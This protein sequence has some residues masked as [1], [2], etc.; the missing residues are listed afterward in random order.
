MGDAEERYGAALELYR[1]TD[2]SVREIC[3][4]TNVSVG[5]FRSYLQRRHRDLMLVRYGVKVTP[6]KAST[7]KLRK[8]R[9][10]SPQTHAKYKDAILA[11][12]DAEYIECT[13]SEIA[14]IFHL[15][16]T[17]L[18]NQLRNHFP[19]ILERR[20]KE[21]QRLGINDNR[22][23]G[24]KAES[25]E[26]YA[27]AVEH[28]RNSD[29]TIPQTAEKYNLSYSGLREHVLRY[30]KEL[31]L[32]REDKRRQ[33]EGSKKRGEITGNGQRHL[34]SDEQ[35][36][37]YEKAI[38]LYRT[39]A[40][41]QKE[42]VEA[43]GISLS[44]LRN[45]LRMWNRDVIFERRGVTDVDSETA[46]LSATKHYLKSTAAKYADA[47]AEL[48]KSDVSTAK[49]AKKYGFQAEVFREYLYEHEPE[50]ASKLGMT[51]LTNGKLV[52]ARSATKYDEA[53][54]LFET[55]TETLKSIALRLGLQYNSLSSFV[56]RNRPDAIEKHN[57]LLSNPNH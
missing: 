30:H 27:E 17:G 37:K 45:Y 5:A 56:R 48:K 39:T 40:M 24:V 41:T 7:T 22:H 43:T 44:G 10:Q 26:Q 50:L 12:D 4:Q 18:G 8:Q 57:R 53:I 52:L 3:E 19:E 29:D 25:L 23:R 47:I 54:R 1:T 16:P 6:E 35:T 42:I 31:G 15:N 20:E 14:Q 46:D 51:K 28:L 55:T 9:G 11:C 36:E 13:V 38:E 32:K 49:I 33:A 2:L 34:P 21:R